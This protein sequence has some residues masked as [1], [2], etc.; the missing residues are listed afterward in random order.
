MANTKKSAF[1]I[2]SPTLAHFM[3]F[4]AVGA[5]NY[6]NTLGEI[7]NLFKEN[8]T[9]EDIAGGYDPSNYTIAGGDA[10]PIADHL[11]S[12]DGLFDVIDGGTYPSP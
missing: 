4:F 11:A 8:T 7:L 10:A 12:I 6:R 5:G 3:D 1:P 2:L 9:G